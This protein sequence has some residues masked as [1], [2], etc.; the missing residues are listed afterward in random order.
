V[1][2]CELIVTLH[3]LG[4]DPAS[5]DWKNPGGL[6]PV[7]YLLNRT[8]NADGSFGTSQNVF[9]ATETLAAFLVVSGQGSPGGGNQPPVEKDQYS[10]NIAVVGQSGELLYSPGSATVNKTGKW[11]LTALGALHA[12]GLSYTDDGGFV[13]SIA[14]QA[15]SGMNGWMYKVNGSVPMMQASAKTV[16]EGDQ[17]I[18]WYSKDMNSPGP[19]WDSLFRQTTE[20]RP[21]T[22]IPANLQEQN[23]LLP[24]ALQASD[25]ALTELEK[26]Y[27]LTELKEKT[28]ELYTLNEQSRAVAVVG[29]I[30][31]L[32]LAAMAALKKEMAQNVVDLIQKVTA[33]KGSTI[34]D[35]RAEAALSIPAQALNHDVEITVKK[36]AAGNVQ[37]RGTQPALPSGFRQVSAVYEFGPDGTTFSVPVTL[38]LKV[39]VPPL[40]RPENLAL[41]WYDKTAG[42]WV[43]IP[44]VVDVDRGLILARVQHFSHYTVFAREPVKPF[45]DVTPASFGWA[46]DSIETLAG[47]DIV[48]G[49]DGTRFEPDR[50]VTRA[51][52]ASLL[53]KA[54]SLQI[55]SGTSHPFRDVRAG[56]WYSKAVAA[57]HT[58]GLV[59][60]YGDG[61]FR[62]DSTIT[63]EEVAAML[64]RA[65]KL[66]TTEQK[67]A[68]TDSDKISSWARA[69][70]AAAASQSLIGGFPDGT[71]QPDAT[72]SR[73]Q[74]AVMVYRM[75]TI[76]F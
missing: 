19:T 67:L 46:K 28:V 32:D 70:V 45:T 7:D 8:L 35:A 58:A 14:G 73:A 29:N 24:V 20:Y 15:N 63:R 49:V 76:D 51:E 31:P 13:K 74:C 75:L 62:P 9:G 43:T 22:M 26:A 23:K 37:G 59:T 60:G 16:G 36:I 30:Q 71:F 53:I 57:A 34:A 25:K 3:R 42:K 17:V 48:A 2:D 21:K 50:A 38:T 55:Q 61:T 64:A 1:D 44:A 69:S 27:Q 47:A 56:E 72:A 52:F 11:G 66:Q 41:A 10:V 18:W 40:V 65:M 39:A 4:K 5:A 68:F 12:T 33:D 54:L 6:T